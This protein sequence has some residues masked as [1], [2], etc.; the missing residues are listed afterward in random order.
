VPL[1]AA[2]ACSS[3]TKGGMRKIDRKKVANLKRYVSRDGLGKDFRVIAGPDISKLRP[4]LHGRSREP[5]CLGRSGD[6]TELRN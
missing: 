3:R 2:S 4:S 6:A 1:W 5:E